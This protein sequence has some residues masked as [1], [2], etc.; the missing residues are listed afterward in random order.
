MTNLANP[1]QFFSDYFEALHD[2][3]SPGVVYVH[4]HGN[5]DVD[6]ALNHCEGLSR[7]GVGV[8]AFSWP[9]GALAS[10]RAS[11]EAAV[12][13]APHLRQFLRALD[14]AYG[15]WTPPPDEGPRPPLTLV[16]QSMGNYLLTE[17]LKL[18]G[19]EDLGAFG[20]VVLA[21]ADVPEAGHRSLVDACAAE[22]RRCEV[23]FNRHDIGLPFG[24]LLDGLPGGERLGR[25]TKRKSSGRVRYRDLTSRVLDRGSHTY[26]WKRNLK[27]AALSRVTA[28]L[29]GGEQ[30]P[31]IRFRK[32][33]RS[34]KYVLGADYIV[35]TGIKPKNGKLVQ[36]P[37]IVMEAAGRMTIRADYAWDGPSG[38]MI[39]D[40]SNMRASLVHDA[41]YQLM[42]LGLVSRTRRNAA[43]RLFET[44]CLA[45]GMSAL[46]ARRAYLA[47]RA[48]GEP[49]SR[50]GDDRVVWHF[51]PPR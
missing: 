28:V 14:V 38:P 13:S 35:E 17:A 41:V 37:Y 46:R 3:E 18:G 22:G 48:F 30:P 7:Y 16:L 47:L 51:G 26:I 9:A 44:M 45:D 39:D 40:G 11:R 36:T 43:D 20:T 6:D 10:Y 29:R 25:G 49:A 31:R 24:Q 42:R 34:W 4:G 21:A 8:L 33:K 50:G 12:A 5:P 23:L 1:G 15:D 2:S 19:A 27:P 32:L